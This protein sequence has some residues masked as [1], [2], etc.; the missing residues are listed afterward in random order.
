MCCRT[1]I[2]PLNEE[3]AAL[4]LTIGQFEQDGAG[5][6]RRHLD[7]EGTMVL[8]RYDGDSL[9]LEIAPAITLYGQHADKRLAAS[10]YFEISARYAEKVGG[11]ITQLSNVFGC[12]DVGVSE[13]Y[14]AQYPHDPLMYD[15]LCNGFQALFLPHSHEGEI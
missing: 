10:V 7:E 2:K 11:R 4:I 14:L 15:R 13:R 8:A 5:I 9:R 1:T 12:S 3:M 6:W